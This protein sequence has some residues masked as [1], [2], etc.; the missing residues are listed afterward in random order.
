MRMVAMRL[1]RCSEDLH[2]CLCSY[3]FTVYVKVCRWGGL[4]TGVNPLLLDVCS[5]LCGL[6]APA[7]LHLGFDHTNFRCT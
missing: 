2:R 5:V 3:S 7:C 1:A 6:R 4:G